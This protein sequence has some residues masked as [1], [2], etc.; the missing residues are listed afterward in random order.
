MDLGGAVAGLGRFPAAF[1]VL[2]C[3]IFCHLEQYGKIAKNLGKPMVFIDF[4]GFGRA[5]GLRKP[6]KFDENV[7]KEVK[8]G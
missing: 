2:F 6:Q 7:L 1:W 5:R 8:R 3:N 4:S